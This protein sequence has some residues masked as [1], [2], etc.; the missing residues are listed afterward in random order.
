METTDPLLNKDALVAIPLISSVMALCFDVGYFFGTDINYFTVFTIS[1]HLTFAAEM[2]PGAL[3]LTT[4]FAAFVRREPLP[5]RKT[6][7]GK[8]KRL[9]IGGVV[10]A[11]PVIV[12]LPA[13]TFYYHLYFVGSASYAILI[14]TAI[15]FGLHRKGAMPT[16][17]ILAFAILVSAI[18]TFLGGID[19]ARGYRRTG[20]FT[21]TIKADQEFKAKLV[22][23]GDRGILFYEQTSGR[24]TLL[25]WSEV[26]KIELDIP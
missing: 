23:S 1:E 19:M 3:I 17:S 2:M 16:H 5:S 9:L 18:W 13:L 10:V 4:M 8:K 11:F 21:Y 24:L 15:F 20:L 26:K 6:A 25:P 12:V 14:L 22:R 7:Q